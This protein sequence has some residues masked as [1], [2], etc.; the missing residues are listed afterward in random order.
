MVRAPLR[1]RIVARIATAQAAALLLLAATALADMRIEVEAE[2]EDNGDSALD[3]FGPE[4]EDAYGHAQ[5]GPS[6]AFAQVQPGSLCPGPT[7]CA[8]IGVTARAYEEVDASRLRF[9]G[10]MIANGAGS[11]ASVRGVVSDTLLLSGPATPGV[12]FVEFHVHVAAN[13]DAE[14]AQTGHAG[15]QLTFLVSRRDGGVVTQPG[16]VF[17]YVAVADDVFPDG[18]TETFG[19]GG[20][21]GTAIP[22]VYETVVSVPVVA[23]PGLPNTF[24]FEVEAAYGGFAHNPGSASVSLS[25]SYVGITVSQGTF[26]SLNGY[27]YL[28]EPEGLPPML[29][30]LTGLVAFAAR[31]KRRAAFEP[32][33]SARNSAS[34]TDGGTRSGGSGFG[35]GSEPT[36]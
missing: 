13:L 22:A 16:D 2:S 20:E 25:P 15:S 4:I 31:R 14:R 11:Q 32:P 27:Q 1:R 18:Y 19:A 21:S 17:S 24:S 7:S 34:R 5:S 30:G 3:T 36:R 26:Q 33:R 8:T 6:V 9:R 35:S 29:F 28:P 10:N 23:G 12:M